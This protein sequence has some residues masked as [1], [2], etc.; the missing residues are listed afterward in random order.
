MWKIS[1]V[2]PV[3]NLEN[4]LMRCVAS[5]QSQTYKN[6]EII[7]VDDGSQDHSADIIKAL[8]KEDER[9]LPI[10]KVNGGVTAARLEGIRHASGEWIGFVDGDD[11]IEPNMFEFLLNNAIKYQANISHCGYQM[12]FPDGHINYFY[13]T[14]CLLEHDKITALRELLSGERIEPGLWN[15]LFHKSLFQNLLHDNLMDTSIKINEDLLMN[16]YLFASAEKSVYEDK[17]PYHYMARCSSASRQKL[18]TNKIYDPIKVRRII[19]D[20]A[21]QELLKDAQKSYISACITVY[22]IL[23]SDRCRQYKREIA[24]IRNLILEDWNFTKLTSKKTIIL[25]NLI[26]YFYLAYPLIYKVYSKYFQKHI[27]S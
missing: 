6:L 1:I 8:A 25:A 10:F 9:I 17:C 18:N 3:Y 14:G 7:L 24:E 21:P 16:Y 26:R 15:K 13:D 27:Y 20:N 11:E 22:N 23:V 2:V 5:I 19:L 4:E 12:C